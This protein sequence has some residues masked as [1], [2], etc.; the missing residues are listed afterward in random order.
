[1]K[2]LIMV[3]C[4]FAAAGALFG[5]GIADDVARADERAQTSYAFGQVVG[6]D[7]H[8][9]GLEFDYDAFTEGFRT[10][11][12]GGQGPYTLEEAMAMVQAA[13]QDA[14]AKQAEENRV[15]EAAFLVEN[16]AKETIRI[17]ESGLQ[18]EVLNEGSGAKPLATD[19]VKV[20]YEGSL[21]D[22][23]VFD[24]SFERGEPAEFPLNR[25]IPGWS[26]GLQL[27]PVG[28]AYRFYIPSKIAYGEQGAGQVIPPYATLIF[29][30]ELL[31]I[32]AG[33]TA[34]SSAEIET[35]TETEPEIETE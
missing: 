18:Y 8:Q 28:S 21:V 15:K 14:M 27:M 29:R 22:G 32:T 13:F 25:V 35:E 20:N 23:S 7:L 6:A 4:F 9:T 10:S 30:V 26:E 31:E 16:A 24:S 19:T 11:V 1:M 12:T 5:K 34:E 17:T 33:E 2:Q 3:L